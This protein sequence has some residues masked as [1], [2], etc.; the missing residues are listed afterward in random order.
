MLTFQ[1][2]HG[3][4]VAKVDPLAWRHNMEARMD[5]FAINAVT[6][7]LSGLLGNVDDKH[8]TGV[9]LD[10]CSGNGIAA[11]NSMWPKGVDLLHI[12]KT[13]VEDH[14]II[15]S[16]IGYYLANEEVDSGWIN[17]GR[18]SEENYLQG[19]VVD[20][21]RDQNQI[22]ARVGRNSITGALLL[23]PWWDKEINR[24]SIKIAADLLKDDSPF[25]VITDQSDTGHL[26]LLRSLIG[27]SFGRM[28]E[29][30]Q[31]GPASYGF[32]AYR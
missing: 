16:R 4:K 23:N 13:P 9:W 3:S 7:A 8:L 28:E 19:D 21:A 14:G 30:P 15:R 20:L 24:A 5:E 10:I 2:E 11:V 22:L 31:A 18:Y 27:G 26:K 6:E 1:G 25:V 32:I 29:Y 17:G 12:D